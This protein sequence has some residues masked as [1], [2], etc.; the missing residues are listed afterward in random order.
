MDGRATRVI[1]TSDQ[2]L[3]NHFIL[4]ADF[5]SAS[6]LQAVTNRTDL[7]KSQYIRTLVHLQNKWNQDG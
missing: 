6:G 2:P 7:I 4:Y 5:H 3:G 1:N